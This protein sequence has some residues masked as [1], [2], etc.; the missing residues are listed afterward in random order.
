MS[1]GNHFDCEMEWPASRPGFF[2]GCLNSTADRFLGRLVHKS[3]TL[4]FCSRFVAETIVNR[5]NP[6]NPW[7]QWKGGNREKCR[8]SE[9]IHYK[10]TWFI[11]RLSGVRIP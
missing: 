2:W 6:W 1:A 10:I 9:E 4:I 8:I 11:P 5:S 3:L 7:I